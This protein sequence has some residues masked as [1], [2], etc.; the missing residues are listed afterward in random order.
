MPDNISNIVLPRKHYVL[1]YKNA[2]A[3]VLVYILCM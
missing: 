3:C 1:R 2:C